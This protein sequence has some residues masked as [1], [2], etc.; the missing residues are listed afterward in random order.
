[1]EKWRKMGKCMKE[2][3]KKEEGEMTGYEKEKKT[4]EKRR[5]RDERREECV[6]RKKRGE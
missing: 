1:M 5:K 3:E 6:E 4:I 2:G